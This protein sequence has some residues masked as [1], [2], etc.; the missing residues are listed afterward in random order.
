MKYTQNL[1]SHFLKKKK[2][3]PIQLDKSYD[4]KVDTEGCCDSPGRR[5]IAGV[6]DLVDDPGNA[7]ELFVLLRRLWEF[8]AQRL[9][10]LFDCNA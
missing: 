1:H 3:D 7:V 2:T 5:S 8:Q 6:L 10:S 4:V 9:R